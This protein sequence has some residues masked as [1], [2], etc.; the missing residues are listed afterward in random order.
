[1]R[2]SLR[3]TAVSPPRDPHERP[4]TGLP[5][6][7]KQ[8][9]GFEDLA[10]PVALIHDFQMVLHDGHALRIETLPLLHELEG[11]WKLG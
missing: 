10:Y 1:M 3:Y 8:G 4:G 6:V 5:G 9:Q 7:W 2:R 11:P